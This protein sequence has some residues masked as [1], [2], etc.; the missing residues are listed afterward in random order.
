MINIPNFCFKEDG[1][2][3]STFVLKKMVHSQGICRIF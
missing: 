1:G 3:Q 2:A